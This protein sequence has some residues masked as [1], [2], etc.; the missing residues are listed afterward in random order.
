[1]KLLL[2]SNGVTNPTIHEALV[3]LLGKPVAQSSALFVA[4]GMHPFPGGGGGAMDAIRGSRS[5]RLCDLGWGSLG[6]LELTALTSIRPD[7]W[8]PVLEETDAL[9]VWGGDVLYLHHWM[10]R[11]GLADLL[12]SLEH[13]VYV[14]VSAG[15]IVMTPHNCDAESNLEWVPPDSDMALGPETALGLVDF[16]LYVHLDNPDPIFVDH[17]LANIAR[18][19]AELPI[20]SYALDDESAVRVSDG[21]VDVVSEG[22]WRLF[23]PDGDGT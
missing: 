6:L 17:S 15:S 18:V 13:L 1:M 16:G 20:A 11:S 21:T 19:A 8:I 10:R 9:L 12:P 23:T 4:T 3:G 5:G 14:G 7:S 2:T 22:H